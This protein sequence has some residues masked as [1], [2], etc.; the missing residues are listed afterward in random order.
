M[1]HPSI[2][3][4][5]RQNSDDRDTQK[6]C[7]FVGLQKPRCSGWPEWRLVGQENGEVITTCDAHLAHGIR[8]TGYPALVDEEIPPYRSDDVTKVGARKL[9]S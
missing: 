8:L 6:L 3:N 9:K 7:R 4:S 1:V 5:M 2:F